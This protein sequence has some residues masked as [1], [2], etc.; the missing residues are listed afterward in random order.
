MMI[1]DK[2]WSRYIAMLRKV[3]DRA[4]QEMLQYLATHEWFLNDTTKKAAVD[5]AFALATKYGEA[6]AEAACEM[7][8]AI[9]DAFA[10]QFLPSAEPAATATYGEVA[11]AFYGT[12]KTGNPDIIADAIGR[13][14]K[15]A[16]ADTT[17]KNAAR[18]GAQFAWIPRGDTCAFC[19]TLASR[20]WQNISKAALRNGHAEHIHANCDC[21]YA[22]RFSDD[23]DVEGYD[24]DAYLAMYMEADPGGKPKDKINA[25]RRMFYAESKGRQATNAI[26][27]LNRNGVQIV[28]DDAITEKEKFKPARRIISDLCQEYDTRLQRVTVGAE[29]AAG[30]VDMSGAR[31]RLNTSQGT[32]VLHEFAHTL[33]N[34]MA[35]KYGVTNDS[36]FWKDIRKIY[37]EYHRDV[38]AKQ[39]TKRF[40]S[41]YEHSSRNIDEF[42]CEAFA[43]AKAK[44]LG[45]EIPPKY[46]VDFT[47]SQKVL[48][49]VNKY[50]KKKR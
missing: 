5:Y 19:I 3:N 33:A 36:G 27:L 2:M 25:M 42:M 37:R 13:L 7:Y 8:D 40:I 50:F 23:Q 17:L 20:G 1:S 30:D 26:T 11:K 41:T 18:D 39:E 24:P 44:E 48:E 22:V 9:V 4:A 45:M 28:F 46:G 10:D 47:Y 32:V 29:K 21:T 34:S 38:D 12:S 49:T 35:D 16:G 6:A 14:V 31:M 43:H 15:Q